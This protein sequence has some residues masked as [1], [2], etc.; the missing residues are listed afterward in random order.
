MRDAPPREE[1]EPR[2]PRTTRSLLGTLL[3]YH[4]LLLAGVGALVFGFARNWPF[5]TY[6][7]F[8]LIIAGI[9]LQ[10]FVLHWSADLAIHGTPFAP[11]L[12]GPDAQSSASDPGG[13]W[14]CAACGWRGVRGAGSC[15]RCGKFLV[16]LSSE[17][18]RQPFT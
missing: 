1:P 13:R 10:Q 9:A 2:W 17:P 8:G 11:G 14:L 15:P 12:S 5:W 7:G 6:V 4:V 18:A 16:R 3:A